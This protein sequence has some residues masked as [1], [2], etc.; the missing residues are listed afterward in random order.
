MN[1]QVTEDW[2]DGDFDFQDGDGISSSILNLHPHHQQHPDPDPESESDDQENDD[3]QCV[4]SEQ[5]SSDLELELQLN[6]FDDDQEEDDDT[7]SNH[8]KGVKVDERREGGE[9]GLSS[10]EIASDWDLGQDDDEDQVDT[11]KLSSLAGETLES[12]RLAS[13]LSKSKAS[14]TSTSTSTHPSNLIDQSQFTGTITQLNSRPSRNQRVD[15]QGGGDWDEDLEIP[16]FLP[17]LSSKRTSRDGGPLDDSKDSTRPRSF[18]SELELEISDQEEEGEGEGSSSKSNRNQ[19]RNSST[20]LSED[21]NQSLNSLG[22]IRR[23]VYGLHQHSNYTSTD[24]TT[25]SPSP[26]SNNHRL[27]GGRINH[28]GKDFKNRLSSSS[29]SSNN[30]SKPSHSIP[31]TPDKS[32]LTK[33]PIIMSSSDSSNSKQQQPSLS[34]SMWQ[35]DSEE[36]D[37]ENDFELSPQLSRL[38]LNPTIIRQKSFNTLDKERVL[39]NEVSASSGSLSSSPEVGGSLDRRKIKGKSSSKDFSTSASTSEF[40]EPNEGEDREEEEENEDL[41]EGLIFPES[42]F[43]P[44]DNEDQ[45]A[46]PVLDR[47]GDEADGENDNENT[48]LL[49][50]NKNKR[51]TKKKPPITNSNHNAREKLQA[52]LDARSKGIQLAPRLSSDDLKSNLLKRRNLDRRFSDDDDHDF[53]KGLVITDDLELSPSRLKANGFSFKFKNHNNSSSSS[54]GTNGRGGTSSRRGGNVTSSSTSKYGSAIGPGRSNFNTGIGIGSQ[55]SISGIG[56][57]ARNRNPARAPSSSM[58]TRNPSNQLR[59]VT[60][61]PTSTF[62]PPSSS[63]SSSTPFN[64][65]SSPIPNQ[66]QS[67]TSSALPSVR[68]T[69]PSSSPNHFSHHQSHLSSDSARSS[70]PRAP[71]AYSHLPGLGPRQQQLQRESRALRGEKSVGNLGLLS[72]TS[73]HPSPS[74]SLQTQNQGPSRQTIDNNA[75]V[76]QN[77]NLSRTRPKPLS[78]K[79]SLPTLSVENDDVT[80]QPS[81]LVFNNQSSFGV[82]SGSLTTLSKSKSG[83]TESLN[84]IST[85][86]SIRPKFN[87]QYPPSRPN[88]P[89]GPM[90]Y[91]V[92]TASSLARRTA[93]T[94]PTNQ[95]PISHNKAIRRTNQSLG[96]FDSVAAAARGMRRRQ[97]SR[98][99]GDGHELDGFDDLPVNTNDSTGFRSPPIGSA[100]S[101][102]FGDQSGSG[103]NTPSWRRNASPL[104]GGNDLNSN[105]RIGDETIKSRSALMS[106]VSQMRD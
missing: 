73:N 103:S 64:T 12:L 40:D 74:S 75:P 106:K 84:Q 69:N 2:N 99:Y 55:P 8:L 24:W 42:V 102:G 92:P 46:E 62:V 76:V 43:G 105:F 88:T 39:W 44:A 41:L 83:S 96:S 28:G 11:I 29:I 49:M 45:K 78:R 34:I 80:P 4:S 20:S 22:N 63:S 87:E 26:E 90:R 65:S 50:K 100:L 60:P 52:M 32:T 27:Q 58:T 31:M 53:G 48:N 66:G 101:I 30:S 59:K 67:S 51:K 81:Q 97:K 21:S 57:I 79:R 86:E 36:L 98:H 15:M 38:D 85:Y 54:S 19:N 72:R 47:D 94:S 95:V 5:D 70:P 104:T 35:K 71:S 9:G 13:N 1:T 56:K 68:V 7:H 14:T 17:S 33:P 23:N 6:A 93:Q 89:T 3:Q 37:L 61:T 82:A 25:D 18:T 10:L 16:D 91:A 77:T